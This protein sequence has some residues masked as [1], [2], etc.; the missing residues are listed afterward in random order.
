MLAPLRILQFFAL[1]GIAANLSR[2]TGGFII[3][4]DAERQFLD[5]SW[6]FGLAGGYTDDSLKVA[7]RNSSGD[8]QSIFGALY[9]KVSYGALDLK[10]GAIIAS[11]DTHTSR[12]IIFPFF[13]DVASASYGGSAAQGFGELGYRLPFHQTL[14]SFVPGYPD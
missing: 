8:Y 3:G 5:G 4:A 9:G 2:D 10:A 12:S 1:A 11:T 7:A 6:R 13:S 14:W